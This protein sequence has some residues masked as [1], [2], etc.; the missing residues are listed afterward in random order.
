MPNN[1]EKGFEGEKIATDYLIQSGYTI[2]ERNWRVNHLEIDIIAQIN[3]ILVIVEVK[4]RKNDFFGNPEEFV[5]K[6][7]QQKLIKAAHYYI[8]THNIEIETRFDVM[9]IIQHPELKIE[10][11]EGA[12]YPLS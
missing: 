4:L 8:K 9:S 11:I 10:H 6:A 2:I 1:T 12:F 5:T 7:K 3:T